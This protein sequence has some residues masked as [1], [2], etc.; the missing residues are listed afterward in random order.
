MAINWKF[1]LNGDGRDDGFNDS[2]MAHFSGAKFSS[3]VR[4]IIQ[5]SLDAA[6][7]D[8]G[9]EPVRVEFDVEEIDS[10]KFP[11]RDNLWQIFQR[12]HDE[13]ESRK[14]EKAEKF[15]AGGLDILK[16]KKIRMLKASDLNTTGLHNQDGNDMFHALTKGQGISDKAPDAG[17]SFGIGKNAPYVFSG[18]RT[19]FYSTMYK[20]NGR[21]V[22]KAQGRSIL[23]SHESEKGRTQGTGFYGE[24]ERLSPVT[25]DNIP[26]FLTREEQ[27]TTVCVAGFPDIKDWRDRIYAAVVSSFF[28]AIDDKKLSVSVG[29]SLSINAQSL[30]SDFDAL[31]DEYNERDDFYAAVKLGSQLYDT[32]KKGV[33]RDIQLGQLG[34]CKV[35]IHVAEEL[36]RRIG[37]IRNTGMMIT[38]EQKQLQGLRGLGDYIAVCTCISEHGNKLLRSMENPQHNAFEPER[39]D[40]AKIGDKALSELRTAIYKRIKQIV[41]STER[42][43]V[44]LDETIGA[45]PGEVGDGDKNAD[46]SDRDFE[47]GVIIKRGRQ[48]TTTETNGGGGGGKR[49]S[50]NLTKLRIVAGKSEKERVA[51]FTPTGSGKVNLE[52]EIVGDESPESLQLTQESLSR[53]RNFHLVK[54]ERMEFRFTAAHDARGAMRIKVSKGS[55]AGAKQ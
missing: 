55:S 44:M 31:L 19:V 18:L 10:K 11:E 52:V 37:L 14:D 5:N 6:R 9:G 40:E 22:R 47:R 48:P 20:E 46:A 23:M 15:F 32:L 28:A 17:G 16:S 38:S 49:R 51:Y 1:P 2:G 36:P 43:S 39:L 12:C 29:K 34:H 26:L 7:K 8:K 27:G 53:A 25:G 50:V 30:R 24:E 54:G 42:K 4:E 3:L 35:Q 41:V 13:S 45:F 33:E 21:T